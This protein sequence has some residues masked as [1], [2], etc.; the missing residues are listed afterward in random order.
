M[1]VSNPIDFSI[2]NHAILDR[3]K[4]EKKHLFSIQDEITYD[5]KWEKLHTQ[6]VVDRTQKKAFDNFPIKNA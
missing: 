3:F 2:K 6:D 1:Y 5:R 4:P